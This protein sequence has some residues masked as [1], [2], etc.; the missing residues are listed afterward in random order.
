MT[1]TQT[2]EPLTGR[3]EQCCTRGILSMIDPVVGATVL[4]AAWALLSWWSAQQ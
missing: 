2:N 4:F 3:V 1:D